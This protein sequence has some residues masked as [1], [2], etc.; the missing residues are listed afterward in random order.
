MLGLARDLYLLHSLPL[1]NRARTLAAHLL[2]AAWV[3]G[4]RIGYVRGTTRG[5]ADEGW[6]PNARIASE[7]LDELVAARVVTWDGRTTW[8]VHEAHEWTWDD[9]ASYLVALGQWTTAAGWAPD[10]WRDERPW[11]DRARAA[12]RAL[13]PTDRPDRAIQ[14][15]WRR[16]DPVTAL[17][18]H[19]LHRL[20]R[21]YSD[22]AVALALRVVQHDPSLLYPWT[23]TRFVAEFWALVIRGR[24]FPPLDG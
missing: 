9:R 20:R 22:E 3:D 13:P 5:F 7:L 1:R 24:R 18:L 16:L 6:A 23:V 17:W 14:P 11:I 21:R 15:T 12:W 4:E 2:T 19:H 8:V 10:T